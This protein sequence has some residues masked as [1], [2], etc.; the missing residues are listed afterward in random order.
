MN[1]L[2]GWLTIYLASAPVGIGVAGS[3]F[4]FNV[5]QEERNLTQ[6]KRNRLHLV[7]A[8]ENNWSLTGIILSPLGP[9]VAVQRIFDEEQSLIQHNVKAGRPSNNN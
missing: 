9:Q 8:E 7:A 5:D 4:C 3:G 2:G 1:S 6:R